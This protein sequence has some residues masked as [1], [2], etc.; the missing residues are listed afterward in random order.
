MFILKPS[1]AAGELSPALYG[2]TDL[3]KYD[4]GAAELENFLVLR[5]GGIERRPGTKFIA[6][7]N[8]NKLAR[9]IP[10]QYAKND[11]CVIEITAGKFR[12]YVDGNLLEGVEV[13]NDYQENELKDI[14]YCQSAD[15]MFLTHPNHWPATL[16]RYSPTNWQYATMDI[17]NRAYEDSNT[18]NIKIGASATTGT[19]TLTASGNYFNSDMLGQYIR[20]GHTMK[21]QY[22]KM[23]PTSDGPTSITS[24]EILCPPQGTVYMETFGFWSGTVELQR[25]DDDT[26]QWVS[27]RSQNNN[28]TSNYNISEQ[29]IFSSIKRYR[30]YSADFDYTLW[31][32]ENAKQKGYVVLQCFAQGYY[33]SVRIDTIQ[34]STEASATV[35]DRLASTDATQDFAMQAWSDSKGY[36]SCVGFY[37]DRLCFAGSKK[38]PQT[39]WLSKTGDYYNFGVSTPQQAD[40]AITGTLNNGQMNG[41]KALVPFGELI[42]LTS[43]G[44]Y[45]LSGGNDAITPTNQQA[46]AQ[47]YRGINN[48]TP[49]ICGGRIVFVQQM[50]SIVRDFAYAYDQ[51][52]YTGDDVSLLA[53][54][55]FDGHNIIAMAYQQTPNSIVWCVRDDGVLL[56]MTYIKEQEVF[57]WHK[58]TTQGRFVDVCSIAGENEDIVY[59]VIERNGNYY[60]EVMASQINNNDEKKQYFVDCY[61]EERDTNTINGLDRFNGQIVQI[62]GDG[63][64]FPRATVE[65]GSVTCNAPSLDRM[66]VGLG[67]KSLLKTM[68]IEFNGQDGTFQSRKKRLSRMMI[69]LKNSRGGL[70]GMDEFNLAEIKWRSN[71]FYNT[72]IKLYT[73]KKYVVVP[74]TWTDTLSLYVVQEDPLPMAVLSIV[75]EIVAGG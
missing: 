58:H 14:K 50:G 40:D 43:G 25:F 5:Y 9:L 18:G 42:M 10:F 21:S 44:A 22:I 41:I 24:G 52:K 37:E 62:L 16:T 69:Y 35:I 48:L 31:A 63:S 32:N 11:T 38:Y 54:H 3:A 55:L 70:F 57:A 33:G 51:D 2:R 39:Y 61:A 12:F 64:V 27:V 59:F 23:Q 46:K 53:S 47:E 17:K 13:A 65:N 30:V 71:E 60:V 56:G 15:V 34:S 66:I 67:Y 20:L 36:P 74:S 68:P 29:N 75:P 72:A 8:Q 45:K 49:V 28:H 1:F 6:G 73:G 7:T 4:I 26:S 19:V